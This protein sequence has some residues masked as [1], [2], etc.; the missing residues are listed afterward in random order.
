MFIHPESS[1]ATERGVVVCFVVESGQDRASKK[2]PKEEVNAQEVF[3]SVNVKYNL[4]I[5]SLTLD[6]NIVRANEYFSAAYEE[7]FG[8]WQ[9]HPDKVS[10]D[11]V[12]VMVQILRC[13]T[14]N[15]GVQVVELLKLQQGG[16][17]DSVRHLLLT[18]CLYLAKA[19]GGVDLIERVE[20]ELL[21]SSLKKQ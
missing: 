16:L 17:K 7:L 19:V 14:D 8:F 3:M 2:E 9:K 18:N 21:A 6:Q 20:S 12:R 11:M 1:P 5:Q 4:G 13:K 10:E 15:A